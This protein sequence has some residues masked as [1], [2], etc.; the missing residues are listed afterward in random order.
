MAKIQKDVTPKTH[1]ELFQGPKYLKSIK[2]GAGFQFLSKGELNEPDVIKN[3]IAKYRLSQKVPS[4]A[5]RHTAE[6]AKWFQ[7][8]ISKDSKSSA[9]LLKKM[10]GSKYK[11]MMNPKIGKM[12]LFGYA[13]AVH[14][15]TLPLWDINPLIFPFNYYTSKAG[16]TILQG[17]N[18][19]YLPPAIRY[20]F[21]LELLKIKTSK[22]YRPNDKLKLSWDVINAVTRS[23]IADK[24]VHGYRMDHITNS[25]I[26]IPAP[27]W[28]IVVSLPLAAWKS[29]TG[30]ANNAAAWK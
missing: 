30:A 21:L 13:D 4:M 7:R 5:R 1:P 22:K 25:F 14:R 12:Y 16:N 23:S 19:H 17:V 15:K 27:S 24:V 2:H 18:M 10:Y 20:K 29:E 3:Y 11:Q 9:S 8:R 28:E 26:E 6:S